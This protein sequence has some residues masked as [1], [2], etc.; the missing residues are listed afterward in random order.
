M[1][2]KL[3][4]VVTITFLLSILLYGLVDI[5]FFYILQW[6]FDTV[7]NFLHTWFT[8]VTS[9][10]IYNFLL[11]KA[12]KKLNLRR[13]MD[14][15]L[16]LLAISIAIFLYVLAIDLLFYKFY[17]DIS[18]LKEETTFFEYDLPIMAT[19]LLVGSTFFYQK[20][21]NRP[22]SNKTN[23]QDFSNKGIEKL[24][25]QV[26]NETLLINHLEVGVIYTDQ[27]MVWLQLL[28][29]KNFHTN[30]ILSKLL[31]DL[32]E[33]DFFRLNRQVIISRKAIVGFTKLEYQ[34]L[35]VNL[36]SQITYNHNL[37]VSKYSAPEFKK[38]IAHSN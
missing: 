33:H 8:I 5:H 26:G 16:L 32:N 14:W 36:A 29:G 21:Y 17:Y 20:Y 25:L 18:S 24:K 4:A 9:Y 3:A 22:I 27:G 34:K 23:T 13:N 11:L 15:V 10:F 2:K 31:E 7:I 19:M 6:D 1:N 30:F 12:F 38:W 28:N 35:K 37:V